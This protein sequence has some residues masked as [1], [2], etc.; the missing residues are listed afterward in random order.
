MSKPPIEL[1]MPDANVLFYEAF[2]SEEESQ[3]YFKV[4]QEKIA[5][6]QQELTMFGKQI[7]IPRLIAWYG[8]DGKNYSYSGIEH[9]SLAWTDELLKIKVRVEAVAK[10]RFNS[11]LLNLYRDENDSVGWHSD[12]ES[13]L[14]Q[15]PVIASISFG[16]VR[17]FQ[18]KHRENDT[19]R[20]SID[21]T[22]GSLL[23]MKGSTQHNWKHRIPK[24]KT[25]K[26]ARMNLTFRV[27][28]NN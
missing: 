26:G 12:D 18:F 10:I 11:V 20:Q 27:I 6:K 19:L 7:M 9:E 8:D 13:E 28:Q 16:E 17:Q 22:S 23:M 21:L 15:D 1:D 3:S 14:G 25:A 5:W 2:F 4:L 24:T